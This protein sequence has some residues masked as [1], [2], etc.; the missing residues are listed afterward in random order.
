MKSLGV[1]TEVLNRLWDCA[2]IVNPRRAL[3]GIGVF[4]P[5]GVL[6]VSDEA[7]VIQINVELPAGKNYVVLEGDCETDEFV[8][9]NTDGVWLQP[10]SIPN[11]LEPLSFFNGSYALSILMDACNYCLKGLTGREAER[12]CFSN[13]GKNSVLMIGGVC[14]SPVRM[15][16]AL[17]VFH[18][19][20]PKCSLTM[21]VWHN[22][23]VQLEAKNIKV[24]IA[25]LTKFGEV[26][27]RILS[28]EEAA[29]ADM[30]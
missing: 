28:I 7:M 20:D 23:R 30:L 9:P 6:I 16:K 14:F 22:D 29:F 27:K 24:V 11:N 26:S 18:A 13:S 19:L 1:S 4:P 10:N 5:K 2:A 8:Y 3:E 12:E 21:S 15:L 25:G 17:K